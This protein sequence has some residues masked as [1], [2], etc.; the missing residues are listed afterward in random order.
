MALT[1]LPAPPG[2]AQ[3]PRGVTQLARMRAKRVLRGG[4]SCSADVGDGAWAHRRAQPLSLA[5]KGQERTIALVVGAD[6]EVP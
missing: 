1:T 4:Q 6:H 2:G 3:H 5:W